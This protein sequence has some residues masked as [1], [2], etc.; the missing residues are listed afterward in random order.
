[1]CTYENVQVTSKANAAGGEKEEREDQEKTRQLF[2]SLL[3]H[4]NVC[5][6]KQGCQVI[7]MDE[8]HEYDSYVKSQTVLGDH[9]GTE[10][11]AQTFSGLYF[12]ASGN[13]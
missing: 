7:V 8:Q 4:D 10:P 9:T 2:A 1:M 12:E 13:A 6:L 5:C 11:P 3:H